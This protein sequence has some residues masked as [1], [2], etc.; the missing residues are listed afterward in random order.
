M[1]V[2]DFVVMVFQDLLHILV[3]GQLE[4]VFSVFK[5]K[6]LK[7]GW[8]ER[9]RVRWNRLLGRFGQTSTT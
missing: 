9:V 6:G 7:L 5:S 4:G 2:W 8:I 1:C 3:G